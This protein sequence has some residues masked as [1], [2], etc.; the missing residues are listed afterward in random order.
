[1][2]KRSLDLR[3]AALSSKDDATTE[4]PGHGE[5][6]TPPSK[7]AVSRRLPVRADGKP[8]D[9]K[10]DAWD[11]CKLI[12]E[13]LAFIALVFYTCETRRTNNLTQEALSVSGDQFRQEQRPYIWLTNSLVSPEFIRQSGNPRSPAGQIIWGYHFTNYGRTPALGIEFEEFM[14]L[15]DGPF[16]KTFMEP[17]QSIGAPLPPNKD[18]FS[19]V[20]SEPGITPTRFAQLV[21]SEG[22]SIKVVFRYTDAAHGKYEAGFCL[23]RLNAGAIGYCREGNYIK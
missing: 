20:V 12:V 3:K 18:D 17:R 2:D 21:T 15:G 5:Q 8:T 9:Q 23:N 4:N 7:H 11:W 6:D 16:I 10:R 13:F 1:M 19:T 14:K 22:I